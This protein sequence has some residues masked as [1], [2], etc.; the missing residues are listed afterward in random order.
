VPLAHLVGKGRAQALAGSKSA[1]RSAYTGILR[2][3][4]DADANIPI[5]KSARAEFAKAQV[6]IRLV[7][8]QNLVMVARTAPLMEE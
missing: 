5:L 7:R 3:V 6:T 2:A 8:T 4:K 1:A